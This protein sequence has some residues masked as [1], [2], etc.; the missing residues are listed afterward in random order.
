[1]L[2]EQEAGL[3]HLTDEWPIVGQ[4]S[5]VGSLGPTSQSWLSSEWLHSIS[6]PHRMK[7]ATSLHKY[8]QLKLVCASQLNLC[9]LLTSS[10]FPQFL[11]HSSLPSIP[12][13]PQFLPPLNSSLPSI[14]PSPQFLPPLNS[15]LPS[16]P[17]SPQFLPPLNSS[18]PSIL[19]SPQFFPPLN[20]SLPSI[21]PSPQFFPPL[22]S[23]LPSILPSP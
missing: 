8:P 19:P 3:E 15:S 16:I 23:S 22:N 7:A 12:P 5:S 17:P 21:L 18:L 14:P 2:C 10:P 13:S 6:S 1:M 20:S 9:L 4:F 11:I